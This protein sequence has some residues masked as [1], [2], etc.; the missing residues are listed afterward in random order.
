MILPAGIEPRSFLGG[1]SVSY[2]EINTIAKCENAWALTYG[3]PLRER[4]PSSAA[5]Q[6]GTEVHRLVQHLV[7]TGELLPS[8]D[9][10]AAWL[11]D[12]YASFYGPD[13][14]TRFH[15]A[16]VEVPLLARLPYGGPK[17]RGAVMAGPYFFGFAD[18]YAYVGKD[19]YEGAWL[20]E[21]KSAK[22]FSGMRQLE[23]SSQLP[24]YVWAARKMGLP[25]KGVLLDVL[26]TFK[27]VKKELAPW[28][29]FERRWLTFTDA[30]LGLAVQQAQSA[31]TVRRAIDPVLGPRRNALRAIGP[32]CSW[33][34]AIADCFGLSLEIL[35]EGDDF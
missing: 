21:I 2:S 11:V 8:E 23:Q 22:D 24:L 34:P 19:G 18:G 15:V 1:D 28:E 16:G 31:I 35:D 7:R 33:C 29:S 4:T 6:R 10:L 5:Q 14:E 27:P 20:W 9:D 13:L 12:R 25:V 32:S 17:V 30:E 26:R 3:N